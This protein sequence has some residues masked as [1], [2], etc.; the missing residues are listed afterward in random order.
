[1]PPGIE[2]LEKA[3]LKDILRYSK[4]GNEDA[5]LVLLKRCEPLINKF[6]MREGR[7]DPDLKSH[8]IADWL[9]VIKKFDP[10]RYDTEGEGET[11]QP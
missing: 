11:G 10:L 6:S 1:M 4:D 5:L 2:R 8:L 3:P 9:Y 7:F